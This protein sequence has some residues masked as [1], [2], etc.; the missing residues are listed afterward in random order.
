MI[1]GWTHVRQARD[2]TL[3]RDLIDVVTRTVR[4]GRRHTTRPD[5]DC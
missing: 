5:Q 3:R 4:H 1:P 2:A